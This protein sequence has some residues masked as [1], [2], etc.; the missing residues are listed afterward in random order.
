MPCIFIPYRESIRFHSVMHDCFL[1]THA[2]SCHQH[3]VLQI[4]SPRMSNIDT[5]KQIY[6]SLVVKTFPPSF[7]NWR[8]MSN[9]S[10]ALTNR[11]LLRGCKSARIVTRSPPFLNHWG[12]FWTLLCSNP[13]CF[14]KPKTLSLLCRMC[15]GRTRKLEN[16]SIIKTKS[17]SGTLIPKARSQNT[18]IESIHTAIGLPRKRIKE[19]WLHC[20]IKT[21]SFVMLPTEPTE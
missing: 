2:W 20:I 4:S 11:K 21:E 16:L 17:T 14:L 12:H 1:I 6:E 3:T 8:R 5:V 19:Y 10:T 15:S 7:P 18:D 13:N 9:G